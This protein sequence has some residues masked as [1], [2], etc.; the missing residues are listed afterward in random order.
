MIPILARSDMSAEALHFPDPENLVQNDR[1]EPAFESLGASSSVDLR[2]ANS[3]APTAPL[4]PFAHRPRPAQPGLR[5]LPLDG[6]HWGGAPRPG[7]PKTP[8]VRGDHCLIRVNSGKLRLILPGN[9]SDHGPGDG[10]FIPAGTAFGTQPLAGSA[11]QVLL[12][13]VSVADALPS[14]LPSRMILSADAGNTILADLAALVAQELNLSAATRDELLSASLQ[15]LAQRP[16]PGQP[17]RHGN[18]A[19]ALFASFTELAGRELGRGRTVADLAAALDT[20]AAAIEA[21]CQKQRGC[22]ALQ[23]MYDLR[24]ERARS[25]LADGNQS[26]AAIADELGFTGTAHLNRAF[27]AATGRSAD[28]FRPR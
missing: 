18:A 20:T 12:I 15:M 28:A 8:R 11:G 22:S 27:M 21:A 5:V 10:L 4:R 7:L 6:L 2:A 25:M 23:V 1:V 19:A 16:E 3:T 24:L 14:R 26:L 17:A 9:R 13:P